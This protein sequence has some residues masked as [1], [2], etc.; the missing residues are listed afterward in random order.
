MD[1]I[2]IEFWSFRDREIVALSSLY[3]GNRSRE[4]SKL[5]TANQL[6]IRCRLWHFDTVRLC[7]ECLGGWVGQVQG[8]ITFTETY[9]RM[10]PTKQLDHL[11]EEQKLPKV[12][13]HL[14]WIFLSRSHSP[15]CRNATHIHIN[16]LHSDDE[17]EIPSYKIRRNVART[18]IKGRFWSSLLL[19]NPDLDGMWRQLKQGR[20]DI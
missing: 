11:F 8:E 14:S 18:K 9:R 15:G 7:H 10:I 6:Y 17:P 3:W 13:K 20:P 12:S 19:A 2:I 1:T 5:T 4:G 16:T